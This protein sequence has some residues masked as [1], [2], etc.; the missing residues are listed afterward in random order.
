MNDYE[1]E[2]Q[3]YRNEG[4]VSFRKKAQNYHKGKMT[5]GLTGLLDYIYN[6]LP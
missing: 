2:A 5:S 4:R 1:C 3:N 6:S